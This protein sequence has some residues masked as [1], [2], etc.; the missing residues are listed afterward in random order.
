MPCLALPKVR[1]DLL[2]MRFLA[3]LLGRVFPEYQYT[4]LFPDF[5]ETVSLELGKNT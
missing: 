5:E 4:W 3:D 2:G 1:K